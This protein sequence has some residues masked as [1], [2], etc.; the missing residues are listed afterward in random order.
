M[1][2]NHD[3]VLTPQLTQDGS[4]TFYCAT[5][6]ELFHSHSGAKQEAQ[7]KYVEPCQLAEKARV[8]D[9]LTLLD[10]CYGLGYNSAAA[11]TQIWSVNPHCFI[12]LIAL[13]LDASVPQQAL[14]HQLL[15]GWSESAIAILTTLAQTQTV[16]C[17]RARA[18][19]WLGDARQT[20]QSVVKA[21]TKVDAIFLDPFSTNKCP[22]LWTVEFLTQ[23]ALALKSDGYLA[24]YSCAASVRMALQLAGLNI[25]STVGV[26]RRSPGTLACLGNNRLP[27]LSQKEQEHLATVAAIPYRDP[28]LTN[29]PAI[30]RQRRSREQEASDQEPSSHWKKRWQ[31]LTGS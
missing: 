8:S 23:V 10:V 3:R 25:G 24:T 6:D 16:D 15:G 11:M 12:E 2:N 9:A 21:G 5:F 29:E 17:D 18:K 7:K 19:L 1:Q 14:A 31:R 13:E 30:I 27:P 28:T 4:F 20:I 26:G 22:Q